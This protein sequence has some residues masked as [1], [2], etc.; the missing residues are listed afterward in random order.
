MANMDAVTGTQKTFDVIVIGAGHAGCEAALAAA[1]MGCETLALTMSLDTIAHMP[2]NPAI[3]GLAKGNLVKEIDALGGEMGRCADHT[4]IQ[5]R[6]LNRS[7]GPAV[8]GSRCQSDMYRYRARMR[9]TLEHQPRLTIHQTTVE[10]FIVEQAAHGKARIAGVRTNDGAIYL[11]RTVVITTGTFLNGL[12]HMGTMRHEA[13]RMWEFPSK[14]LPGAL[15]RLN[16][17]LGRLKTGTVPR[18]DRRTIHWD[19]LEEQKGDDPIRKFSFWDSQVE[20]PQ[21]SCFITYTHR[22]TH[23]VIRDN[24]SK[25]AMYSGA[26][27][28]VGPRYCPSIEDKIVKFPDKERHQIFLEPTGLDTTEIYPNGLSTSLPPDVQ[29][30]F[31]RT[32]PG[33]EQVEITRPGYAVEYDYVLPLQL[34]PTLALKDVPNL[35]CAGQINGTSGYEEAAAQG[36][37][38]GVNAALQVQGRPPFVLRRDEAYIGVLVDDLITKGTEEPYRMFTSRA[39]YRILLREDTAD[40]RLSEKGYRIGL[41]PEEHWRRAQEKQRRVHALRATLGAIAVTP[42]PEVNAELEANGQPPLKTAATAAD[43]VRRPE[44]TLDTLTALSFVASRLNLAEHPAEVREQVEFAI[45]YEGY[46][47]RQNQQLALLDRLENI[48]LD[49]GLDYARVPGLSRE[50]VQK[51][52]RFRPDTLGQASRISGITPAAVSILAAWVRAQGRERARAS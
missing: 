6:V 8:W 26:I 44:M 4:G 12:I 2:C 15:G 10:D 40:Q 27:K 11:G 28:G 39:E 21:V 9:A 35:F 5:F 19:G 25:S 1:R 18:L 46:V 22:G 36:L 48:R 16:L 7:K 29:L 50:V 38:A 30:A 33:L 32:I 45:K 17:Q 13:G 49:A 43:L 23:K 41:L 20:L 52:T 24:L 51:L 3:G 42:T 47:E 14:G 37:V 31:L 34:H